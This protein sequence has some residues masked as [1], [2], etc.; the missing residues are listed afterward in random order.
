VIYAGFHPAGDSKAGGKL[1]QGTIQRKDEECPMGFAK[2]LLEEQQRQSGVAMGIAVDAGVLKR[3]KYHDN[4]YDALAGDNTPAYELGNSRFSAGEL[5]GVF[6]SSKEM[7]AAIDSAIRDAGVE[8][9]D[10]V[11]HRDD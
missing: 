2:R 11:K 1:A 3:C 7:A 8:C 9:Y 5:K 4:V 6:S 10:C